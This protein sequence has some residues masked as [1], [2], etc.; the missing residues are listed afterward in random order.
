MI[1]HLAAQFAQSWPL[2]TIAATSVSNDVTRATTY[3]AQIERSLNAIEDGRRQT[4]RDRW[5]PQYVV[6]TYGIDPAALFAFVR[7][8]R[9][10]L[11]RLMA[12]AVASEPIAVE[13]VRMPDNG[14]YVAFDWLTRGQILSLP[15]IAFGLVLL[16]MSRRAPVLQ[17]QLPVAAE[18][19]P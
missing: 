13:F 17:P 8:N 18:G 6:D 12:D 19:K 10:L 15:L 7:D 1:S 4:P 14:V 3:S 5:D 11:R 16:V 2:A 9:L